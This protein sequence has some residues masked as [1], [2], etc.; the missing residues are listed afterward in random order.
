MISA[1]P[2]SAVVLEA[3]ATKNNSRQSP[4]FFHLERSF[5]I[6]GGSHFD[7]VH[8]DELGVLICSR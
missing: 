8:F 6:D 3:D 1:R 7:W 4:V 5:A 2:Q